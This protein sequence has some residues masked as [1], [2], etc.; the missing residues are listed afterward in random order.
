MST[1]LLDALLDEDT[2]EEL[3]NRLLEEG[4]NVERVVDLPVLGGGVDD[5]VV[6]RYAEKNDRVVITHDEGFFKRCM[7]SEGSFRL[8]WITEQQGFEPYEKVEMI[9]N[10]IKMIDEINPEQ[11]PRAIPLSSE[12]LY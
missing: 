8:L 11:R 3:S 5:S 4:H 7:N 10:A 6:H 12:F 9:E 2:S 1:F